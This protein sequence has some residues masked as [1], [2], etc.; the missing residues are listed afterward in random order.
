TASLAWH[1]RRGTGRVLRFG[2]RRPRS[3]M[4]GGRHPLDEPG[5]RQATNDR[6]A[7]AET[8][9]V[10]KSEMVYHRVRDRIL[11]GQYG[12]GFRL[13]RDQLAREFDVSPVPVREAIRRLEAEGL[14]TFTRNVGAEVTGVNERDYTDTM[15]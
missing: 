6:S 9:A 4:M 8:V 5:T 14:V 13:V 12:A 2:Y 3:Y 7:M 1:E 11:S 15:Q 10:S